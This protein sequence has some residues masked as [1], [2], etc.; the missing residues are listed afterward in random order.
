MES[1]MFGG[2]FSTIW[3]LAKLVFMVLVVYY[4]AKIAKK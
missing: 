2:A 4:L 3:I 1:V